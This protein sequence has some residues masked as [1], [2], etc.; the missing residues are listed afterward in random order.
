MVVV[1]MMRSIDP[2]DYNRRCNWLEAINLERTKEDYSEFVR[3]NREYMRDRLYEL[4]PPGLDFIHAGR[5]IVESAGFEIESALVQHCL[6][7]TE[8]DSD[9]EKAFYCA[10]T[11]AVNSCPGPADWDMIALALATFVHTLPHFKSIVQPGEFHQPFGDKTGWRMA[12]NP[13]SS[14][15]LQP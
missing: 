6:H 12:K 1:R 7:L 2:E 13:C 4:R 3:V 9:I 10:I 5:A 15:R 11:A 14:T 8:A